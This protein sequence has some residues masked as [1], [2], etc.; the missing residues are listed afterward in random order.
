MASYY[1]SKV[2]VFS[3]GLSGER[4]PLKVMKISSGGQNKPAVWIDGGIH[5][6][7]WV[8]PAAAT[9]IANE[10]IGK[11]DS[12]LNTYDWYIMPVMNPDGMA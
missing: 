4:R 10:L 12:L 8:T 1:P 2:T 11:S 7:E 6:R 9:F 5:A 3:I